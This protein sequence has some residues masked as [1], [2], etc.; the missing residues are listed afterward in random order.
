MGATYV[1]T[2]SI[3]TGKQEAHDQW[4]REKAEPFWH[5]QR[6]FHSFHLYST[7]IGPGPDMLTL[8]EFETADDI[9]HALSQA[10]AMRLWEE[11]EELVDELE[12]KIVAPVEEVEHPLAIAR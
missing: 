10:Q 6:G 1:Y 2:Y 8:V 5:G 12:T 11:F 7:L 9:T 3:P 4:I